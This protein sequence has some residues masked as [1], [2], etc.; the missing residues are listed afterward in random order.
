MAAITKNEL[1]KIN[2]ELAEQNTAL[3]ARVSELETQLTAQRAGGQSTQSRGTQMQCRERLYKS[4]EEAKD[5][6][7]RLAAFVAEKFPGKYTIVQQ[8][9]RVVCKLRAGYNAAKAA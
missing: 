2:A 6:A 5:N 7:K 1:I 3:R 4:F 8:G 9:E